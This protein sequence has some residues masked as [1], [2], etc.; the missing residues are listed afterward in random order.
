MSA[1]NR[2]AKN[3]QLY[4]YPFLLDLS[5]Q[6]SKYAN[7]G[8]GQRP[9]IY[10]LYGIIEHIGA[11][12]NSGH[13]ISYVS[14]HREGDIA[15][16]NVAPQSYSANILSDICQKHDQH[17]YSSYSC[18][19]GSAGETDKVDVRASDYSWYRI[20][21]SHVQAVSNDVVLNCQAFMLF[22]IRVR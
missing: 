16:S 5:A 11:R 10:R 18:V 13:Y 19:N 4:S 2:S 1:K 20:S 9:V 17:L 12:I 7:V 8:N 21:D 3:T 14:R 6:C 22:Y 15:E